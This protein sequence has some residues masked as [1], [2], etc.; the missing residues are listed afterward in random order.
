[1]RDPA[2]SACTGPPF[3]TRWAECIQQLHDLA[4][5]LDRLIADEQFAAHRTLLC[6]HRPWLADTVELLEGSLEHLAGPAAGSAATSA[7]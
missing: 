6:A 7:R 5:Q 2:G 3:V 4:E 1:M